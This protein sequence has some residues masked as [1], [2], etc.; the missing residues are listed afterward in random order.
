[1]RRATLVRAATAAVVA[2]G[3]CLVTI[4]HLASAGTSG[5]CGDVGKRPWC[6]ASLSPDAR[7]DLLLKALTPDEKIRLLAGVASSHTGQT[8]AIPRVGLRSVF[9]TDDSKGVK[10]GKATALPTT[11]TSLPAGHR[12]G[13]ISS[14]WT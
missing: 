3:S 12:S 4:T 10:Q 5:P 13:Q 2:L 11:L 1:M 8:P 9:L 14:T 6:D 7:A